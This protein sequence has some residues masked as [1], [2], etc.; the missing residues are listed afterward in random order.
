MREE[1]EKGDKKVRRG[2]I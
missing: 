2:V 1:S